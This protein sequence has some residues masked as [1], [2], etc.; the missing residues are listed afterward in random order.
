MGVIVNISTVVQCCAY[1]VGQASQPI[2]S[3]NFGAGKGERIKDTLKYAL[4]SAGFFS[5]MWTLLILAFPNGF[6]RIFMNPTDA[7]YSIAPF[8]MRSYGISFL[9]LP[10]NIFS[11]YYF[12]S[13]MK[14]G[15]SFL[16]SVTRG[17]VVSGLLIYTL[18]LLVSPH[19]VWFAMPVTEAAVA[20]LVIV[21]LRKYTRELLIS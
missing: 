17:L 12:Q 4:Y 21:R 10:L 18:P 15:T 13:L 8:I 20:V 11:T 7:V 14:A 16:V 5:L 3:I 9:L 2:I 19:A 6:I 1:S